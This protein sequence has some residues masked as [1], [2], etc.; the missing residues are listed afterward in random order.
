MKSY[1]KLI[2]PVINVIAVGLIVTLFGYSAIKANEADA[3][4]KTEKE[5]SSEKFWLQRKQLCLSRRILK[6]RQ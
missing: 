2:K 3:A 4:Q 5:A 1:G 6:K